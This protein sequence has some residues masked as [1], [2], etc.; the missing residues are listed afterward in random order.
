MKMLS[1]VALA[2]LAVLPAQSTFN[3]DSEGFIR[4]WLVLAP[5]AITGE[6]GATELDHD[7]LNG[8]ATIKPKAGDTVNIGGVARTWTAHQTSDFAINFLTSFGS[9][10]G[11]YVAA[12]AVTYVVAEEPMN[13]TLSLGTNDQG[14]VWLNGKEVLKHIDARTLDRDADRI[15]VSLLKGQ[16]VLVMKVINEVNDWG[17]CARFL[18]GEA[19]VTNL[20]VTL[21]PQ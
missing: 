21:T 20:K 14:R 6:S 15:P 19:V 1:M 3:L 13:V 7:F 11:E 5:I 12:Y 17:A 10:I 16:N 18:R 4:N 8:E 2:G 9:E